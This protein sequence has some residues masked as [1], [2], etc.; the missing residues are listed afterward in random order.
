MF[1]S[2]M[3]RWLIGMQTGKYKPALNLIDQ[4]AQDMRRWLYTQT[5]KEIVVV[6]H[7]AFLHFLTDDWEEGHTAKG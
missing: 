6:S 4:R 1:R 2:S 3:D 7:G 5:A